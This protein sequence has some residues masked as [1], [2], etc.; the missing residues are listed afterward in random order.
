MTC[1]AFAPG[2]LLP[3]SEVPIGRPIS[4]ARLFVLDEHQMPVPDGEEGELYVGGP[5]IA[6]GYHR[7]P[8]EDAARFVE[9][10]HLCHHC[11]ARPA[12]WRRRIYAIRR[13]LPRARR[14]RGRRLGPLGLGDGGPLDEPSRRSVR[15]LA[16]DAEGL[17]R[18]V[19]RV[20]AHVARVLHGQCAQSVRHPTLDAGE[21]GI[22]ALRRHRIRN[23]KR[24]ARR[25]SQ[26]A[27]R[28]FSAV[29]RIWSSLAYF[30]RGQKNPL[31]PSPLVR[32]TT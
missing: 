21:R 3:T 6:R 27:A 4:N 17:P 25:A 15:S 22:S 20:G 24:I 30:V 19:E 31:S 13:R 18:P 14:P 23:R 32:G 26:R 7:R 16:D 28:I 10:P 11:S 29:S 9:L 12:L 5:V 1:A 8:E 2:D